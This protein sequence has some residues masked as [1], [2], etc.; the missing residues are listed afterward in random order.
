MHSFWCI[1]ILFGFLVVGCSDE[2]SPPNKQGVSQSGPLEA[3][4]TP[5][6]ASALAENIT[7]SLTGG[8][9]EKYAVQFSWPYLEDGKILRIRLGSVLAEVL[10]TQ[11]F[12]THTLDHNQIATFSFDVLDK[13]RKPEQTFTKSVVI[14]KDFVI[15]E[16]SFNIN[17]DTRI[18]VQRVFLHKDFPL[19]IHNHKVEIVTS[20]LHADSMSIETFPVGQTAQP[21]TKGKSGGSLSFSTKKL[22]GRLKIIMRGENGGQGAKG[23]IIPGRPSTQGTPAGPGELK[24]STPMD[25]CLRNPNLCLKIPREYLSPASSHCFCKKYGTAGGLGVQGQRGSRG[26][27]GMSGGDSGSVRISVQEY[28]PLEGL[29]PTLSHPEEDIVSIVQIPGSGGVGGEGGEGQL[30][31]LGGAGQNK[32]DH[33]DCRGPEGAEGAKGEQGEV[34]PPGERGVLGLKCLYIGSESINECQGS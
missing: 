5:I 4:K 18:E 26:A 31:G 22:Y 13:N 17:E 10:P 20:E 19:Y 16:N 33:Q 9:P 2:L 8:E 27:R 6:M 32:L 14:P 7:V 34:G 29:D 24:C 30:G 25:P 23:N 28:I 21:Q 3:S 12:F 1:I 11:T 15:R